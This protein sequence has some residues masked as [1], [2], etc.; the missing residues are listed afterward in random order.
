MCISALQ[1]NLLH[2]VLLRV[3]LGVDGG[4][5][6]GGT[7][8]APF[9]CEGNTLWFAAVFKSVKGFS[10]VGSFSFKASQAQKRTA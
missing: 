2:T 6:F 4:V 5:V 7:D 9:A 10:C 3:K 8:V 1:N